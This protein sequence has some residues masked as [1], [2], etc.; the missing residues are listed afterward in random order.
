MNRVVPAV[1]LAVFAGLGVATVTACSTTGT[2][3]G[4]GVT[5]SAAVATPSAGTSAA[6]STVAPTLAVAPSTAAVATGGNAVTGSGSGGSGTVVTAS[7][8]C[9]IASYE[10]LPGMPHTPMYQPKLTWTVS[11]A[12][13]MALSVDNPGIVGSYGTYGAHG[14][15]LLGDGCYKG[16][17]DTIVTFYSVGGVGAQ[18][19]RT[20]VIHPTMTRPV[21]PPFAS[22][23]S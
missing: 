15:M 13:G 12:T 16:S 19:H 8:A 3:V 21:A 10:D 22:P 5:A 7:E 1:A 20:I 23:T 2:A 14:T 4:A 6:T 17:N 9:V 11:H 18:V